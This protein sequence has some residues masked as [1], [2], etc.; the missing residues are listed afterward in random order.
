[1][2]ALWTSRGS[3]APGRPRSCPGAKDVLIRI[4]ATTV[5][6]SDCYIRSA[7]PSARLAMRLMA[8]VVIGFTRPRRPILGAV[9]TGEIE[10]IGSKVTRFHV[11]DR[12]RA[13]T[14]LR[15]GC[16]A[17]RLPAG[18]SQAPHAGA[19]ESE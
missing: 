13:F 8:R 3:A 18:N 10:A 6:P 16:Y 9:L 19:V 12:V 11:G 17:Q 7:I 4:R 14:T 2:P 1:L 5:T 15:M